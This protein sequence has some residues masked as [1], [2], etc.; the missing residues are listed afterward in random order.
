MLFKGGDLV[1]AIVGA[2]DKDTIRKM[3]EKHLA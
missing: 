2:A 3:V 1:D